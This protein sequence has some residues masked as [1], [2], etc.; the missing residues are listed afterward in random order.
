MAC[1]TDRFVFASG[2]DAR[3]LSD[4]CDAASDAASVEEFERVFLAAGGQKK[5]LKK[6]LDCWACDVP[7]AVE[8]LQRIDVRTI[9]ERELEQ[10]T[11][12]S[13]QLLFLADPRKVLLELREIVDNSVHRTITRQGLVDELSRR[14]Y[15]LRRVTSPASAGV[16]IHTATAR[17]LDGAQRR[18]ILR[19]LVPRAAAGTLLSRLGET[20]TDNVM[21][22]GAGS[23]KTACVV[24]VVEGLR[25]RGVPVLA[26]RLDRLVS[27]S[28][29]A[30][31]GQRLD[32]E[33]SPVLV[34]AAAAEASGRPGVLIV[35]QLDAVSTM[36]GRTSG[37]FEIVERLLQEACGMRARVA[38]HI[39]VVCR[40]FDWRHDP[41]LRQLMPDSDA[42]VAVTEFTIDEVTTILSGAN[43]DPR[44]FQARQLTILQLPQNLSLFLEA[45][46]DT[47][48]APTFRTSTEIFDRY[49]DAKQRLVS[50]RVAPA[51]ERWMEVMETLCDEMTS[52]QQLTVRRERLDG[53]S[54]TYVDQLASEGV[55]TFDGHRYGFGHE[56]FFDYV[57]AR[58]FVNRSEPMVAF[59]KASEQHLFRR[60]Q[61]RQVLAYLRDADH[62][63]Y[64]TELRDL[65]S[66]DEI[67]PHLKDLAFTLLAEITAPTD[68]E[69]T[70]WITW[71]TLALKAIEDDTPNLD[72]LSALAWRRF[73]G[74]RSW[75]EDIDR[76][77]MIEDWLASGNDRLT[78]M[79]VN[80]LRAHQRHSP[81]RVAALLEPYADR[82]GAWA[83]RLR[84]LVEWADHHTSRRFFDL[85][86]HL[87]DNGTLDEARGPIAANST[88]WSMLHTLGENRSEWVPEVLAHRLRRR[89]TVIRAAGENLVRRELLGFDDSAVDMITKSAE[90]APAVFVE[91]VLPLVLE[92]SDAGLTGDRP[93]KHDAVWSI[94]VKT[95]HPDGEE[96]CLSGLASALVALARDHSVDFHDVIADLRRRDTHIANHLLL[97]LYRGGAAHYGDEAITLLSDEPWRFQCG[98]QDSPHWCAMEIIRAVVPHCTTESRERIEAVILG[99]A[100]PYE[101]T[102]NG[103][104]Q[105]GRTQL[106]LLS[107]FPAELR[108]ASANTRF[109]ELVRKFGEPDNEPRGITVVSVESPIEKNATDKMTDDQWLRAIEKYRSGYPTYS[110]RDELKGGAGAL[111][112]ALAARVKE[113]PDRFARLSLRFPADA[114][115][116]YLERTLAALNGTPVASELKLQVC[117]KTFAESRGPCG[118]SITDVLG[119]IEDP[120]PDDAVHMLHWLATEHEDPATEAWQE[121]AGGGHPYYNGDI[122]TNGINTTRGRA[123]TAIQ[124]L[125]LNDA[126]YIDRFHPTLDRMTQ[127]PSAAVRSCVA[128]TLRATAH[129]DPALGMS[130]FQSM[131]LSESRLLATDHVYHFIRGGLRDS[132]AELRPIVEGM[133]RS[134]EPDVCEAGARLA[135][136]AALEH[137]SATDL[138]EEASRGGARHRLGVAQVASANIAVPE[139]R[140]WVKAKLVELFDDDDADV[141]REAASCFRHLRDEA[142]DTYGDLIAAFCDSRA[143]QENSFSILHML[144]DALGRL[145]GMTCMVCERFLDRFAD[146]ARDIQTR[147]VVDAHTIAK[148]TF[149]TYQ[150]HQHDKWTAR[151]LDLIDRVCLEGI[152]GAE[153]EFEQ[154]ER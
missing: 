87:V 117:R 104:K 22:G 85:F 131:D 82:G 95:E 76:R 66:D 23:G 123:A 13:V 86:L 148:L 135:S 52:T 152:V 92:I 50:D 43:F 34:L 77:G 35:D 125:I 21:T 119:N 31:L 57:F 7:T 136:I 32:L 12:V 83:Q 105:F 40:A 84:S 93:P 54:T 146:E 64:V 69:W 102:P 19:R 116:V 41:R 29:T 90:R 115:P 118:Q 38:I 42:Q 10:K 153:D 65:L 139:C 142:L 122:H 112:Q 4:L 44:V 130:L 73:F 79:A 8:R 129:R 137:E 114:N 103:Y 25:E 132:F 78:D 145:P 109:H 94:L 72:T 106:G 49:W 58:V 70:I 39:V 110:S 144:E 18:L 107:A 101:R 121:D 99:Y 24:E 67:R 128:G 3:E 14:G 5:N 48:S 75:F 143:Y 30:A 147:R 140:V 141:R 28:S 53:I 88:F 111:A 55:V 154:F 74:S 108:S 91:H 100:S 26:F 46:F 138:A 1:N 33:E 150:Q 56:S 27:A 51:A 80:Y 61:I 36:S 120:L 17:F 133:L 47:S 113:K 134:S 62:A 124:D 6:L 127:D 98:F 126:A 20:A 9:G 97:A 68:D 60:S 15:L 2:S 89:L 151:S 37:A 16:A 96:A 63:R 45:S 59:L 81:D 149:R 11:R 71:I